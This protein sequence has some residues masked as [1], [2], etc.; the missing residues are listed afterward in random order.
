MVISTKSETDLKAAILGVLE[1]HVGRANPITA[2]DIGVAVGFG[3][4]KNTWVIREAIA[5][6]IK[7][8][9]PICATTKSPEGYFLGETWIE[10]NECAQGLRDRGI[11]IIL[12]RRDLLRAANTYFNGAHQQKLL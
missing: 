4:L 7:E 8:G 12:R 11:K 1:H 3:Q 10:I 9:N 2:V 5:V 6:L